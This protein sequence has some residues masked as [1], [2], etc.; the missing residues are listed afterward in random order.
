ME[1]ALQ[2]S[3]WRALLQTPTDR[4]T[5]PWVG[6]HGP[7]L[8]RTRDRSVELTGVG[9]LTD[10]GWYTFALKG[11]GAPISLAVPAAPD[12]TQ[13]INI[14]H[15]YLVGDRFAGDGEIT[16]RSWTWPDS[17]IIAHGLP[18]THLIEEGLERFQRVSVGQIYAN[19]PLIYRQIE[20]PLGPEEDVKTCFLERWPNVALLN[21]VSPALDV[22]FRLETAVRTANEERR[23]ELERLRVAEEAA[24]ALEA[25]RQ[26]LTKQLGDG[27]SR[28]ALAQV[29]FETA[30]KA[31]LAVGGATLLDW[32]R[33]RTEYVVKYRFAGRRFECVCD[34]DLRIKDSGICLNDYHTG[35]SGDTLFTLESLPGVIQQAI[36]EDVLVVLRHV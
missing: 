15:G 3:P 12:H 1:C 2:V 9:A 29:D 10:H 8:V 16:G 21:N 36:D 35:T 4:I 13:L 17:L 22:A 6:D 33:D 30:A 11:R 5:V 32:K 27:A 23:V 24:R 25:R 31:A 20:M 18:Q 34:T 7:R 28:R 19:G 26:E 14:K